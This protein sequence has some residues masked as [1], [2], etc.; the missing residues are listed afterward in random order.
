M[1][2]E[3]ATAGRIIAGAGR[4]AELPGGAGRARIRNSPS[5]GN[6][7]GHDDPLF[8][9]AG[10]EQVVVQAWPAAGNEVPANPIPGRAA[11]KTAQATPVHRHAAHSTPVTPIRQRPHA[12]SGA[13]PA[14]QPARVLRRSRRRVLL[15]FCLDYLALQPTSSVNGVPV[16]V[17][18]IA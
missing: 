5:R 10:D 7:P 6:C 1:E 3:F 18:A 12:S 11:R 13:V 2:F 9:R 8:S 17:H 14:G 16:T 15:S 4:V